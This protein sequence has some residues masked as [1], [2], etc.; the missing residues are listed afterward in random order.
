MRRKELP[1]AQHERIIGAYISGIKQ[2]Y[3]ETGF[4]TPEKCPGHPKLLTQCDTHDLQFRK[5]LHDKG[6]EEWK[7]VVWSGESKFALFE[8]DGQVR[9]WR[10]PVEAY[11]ED[12]I[13]PT[14][15]F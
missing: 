1:V 3:K 10:K 14:V 2:K 5:Y 4:A 15:K 6:L 13:Q 9:V 7:N 12:C 8:S 11:K